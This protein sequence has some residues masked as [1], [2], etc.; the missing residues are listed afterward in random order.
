VG[1]DG[2][3]C[4]AFKRGPANRRAGIYRFAKPTFPEILDF[5]PVCAPAG[6]DSGK[7]LRHSL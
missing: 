4:F 7:Q 3:R 2:S 1:E 5:A 6:D